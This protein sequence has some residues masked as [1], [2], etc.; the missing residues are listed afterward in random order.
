MKVL[1]IWHAAVVAEYRKKIKSL[2]ALPGV[3]LT[4]LLPSAWREGGR[5]V[6]Y[7][8]NTFVD[9]DF[10][11]VVGEIIH[12]NNIRRYFFINKIARV[13]R[14]F[15][16]DIIDIEEEPYSY[17]TAHTI[18]LNNVLGIRSKIIFH[19]AHNIHKPVEKT[20]ETLQQYTFRRS[21]AAIYRNSETEK[22]LRNRGYRGPAHFCGDGLDLSL[23]SPHTLQ[24]QNVI[25]NL[26]NKTVI[27]YTGKLIKAKGVLDLYDAFTKLPEKFV[28]LLVGDG[29][30]R[31]EI[32]RSA[33]EDGFEER[34]YFTGAV[35]HSSTPNYYR[36]MDVCIIPSRTTSGWKETFG[37]SIVE[38]M[39]C[40]VPVIGSSSGAIPETI[41]DN[42]IIFPEGNVKVL[43]QRITEVCANVKLRTQLI[44][45]GL[46]R[47]E[48]FSW[49]KIAKV[50]ERIYHDIMIK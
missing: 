48:D 46:I 6:S 25:F 45:K 30:L 10:A 21:N 34:V 3:R 13:L 43:A 42:G 12:R 22:Y 28:L 7:E 14:N 19:S 11:T 20:F 29:D 39:A 33:K 31:A 15:R 40:G 35:D 4:L 9:S 2:A 8:Y 27:G 41:G 16:P 5:I 37:R 44:K 26:S 23:F 38:A 24:K 49:E 17:C 1:Y 32:E 50:H 47:A 18:F 36:L